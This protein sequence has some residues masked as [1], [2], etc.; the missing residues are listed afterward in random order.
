MSASTPSVSSLSSNRYIPHEKV[1]ASVDRF[2]HG[3][4]G[5][6]TE[7]WSANTT[8]FLD[9]NGQQC[10]ITQTWRTL[11][12][13]CHS[14]S[15]LIRCQVNIKAETTLQRMFDELRAIG[16]LKH[17]G[18]IVYFWRLCLRLHGVDC[19][20]PRIR[21]LDRLFALLLECWPDRSSHVGLLVSSLRQVTRDEL[22]H[23]LRI[24]YLKAIRTL[25]D[26]IG[27]EN[28][29]VLEM[30]SFYSRFFS[31]KF[32]LCQALISKFQRVW[33]QIYSSATTTSPQP[34]SDEASKKIAIDYSYAYAAYY[35]CESPY[36]AFGIA[37]NLRAA[38][39]PY[40]TEPVTWTA[41]VEAFSFASNAIA[42]IHRQY[43]RGFGGISVA[44]NEFAKCCDA[45]RLAIE[46][47]Q[48]GDRECR[49]RATVLSRDLHRWLSEWKQN[50][51][52][53]EEIIRY[54][55]IRDSIP[56]NTCPA[57]IRRRY[58]KGCSE[59][60]LQGITP[61]GLGIEGP[62]EGCRRCRPK[63]FPSLC[64]KCELIGGKK[65]ASR[66]GVSQRAPSTRGT[67]N[68]GPT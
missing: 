30:V 63:R 60:L 27:D 31:A 45:M 59:A 25:T 16:H 28:L 33:Y 17:P 53:N 39:L 14:A 23:V 3:I 21:P 6:R 7:Q 5:S 46:K 2:I 55:R 4:F 32:V 18:F 20:L 58:C 65:E 44:R 35:V 68:L 37:E 62:R 41:E 64:Q 11:P 54:R 38:T 51:Q 22:K 56:G 61:G 43:V 9:A 24:G 48:A 1:L 52:A 13:R 29:I 10:P 8:G 66:C 34:T 36:L 26:L 19:H 15:I 49:T 12:E 57:C 47:L 50:D 67:P 42:K 40:L